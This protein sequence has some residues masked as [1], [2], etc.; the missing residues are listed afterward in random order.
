MAQL[1]FFAFFFIALQLSFPP[2][3]VAAE[4]SASFTLGKQYF[5]QGQFEDAY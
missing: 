5:D 3:V 2:M 1:R 4:M